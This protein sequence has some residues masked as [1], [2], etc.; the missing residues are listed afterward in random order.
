M[1][2]VFPTLALLLTLTAWAN[3]VLHIMH[4]GAAETLAEHEAT[5]GNEEP[6]APR[7]DGIGDEPAIT[8]DA[9]DLATMA[10]R[11]GCALDHSVGSDGD[12]HSR[13]LMRPPRTA[14]T[15]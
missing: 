6:D 9:L 1:R 13:D 2:L 4:L 5:T 7:N 12:D 14:R 15:A 8:I 10:T 11:S 3:D